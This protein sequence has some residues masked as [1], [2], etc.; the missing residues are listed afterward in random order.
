MGGKNNRTKGHNLERE[1]VRM[2]RDELNFK[3]VKTSRLA[4]KL[5][6]DCKVDIFGVPYLI[7]TKM[8]YAKSRPKADVIFKEIDEK[9]KESFPPEDPVHKYPKILVHKIDG[10]HKYHNL[11]TMPYNDFKTLLLNQKE[12]A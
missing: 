9:L 8:G 11:V 1:I 5:L 6:D 7:Q 4:S 12:A 3:F 10:R 2:F